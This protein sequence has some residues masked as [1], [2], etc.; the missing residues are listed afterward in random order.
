MAHLPIWYLGEVP[1]ADC[2]KAFSELISLPPGDATMG[3]TG[4]EKDQKTRDTIIR[5]ADHSHWFGKMMLDYGNLAN[6]ECNWGWITEGYEAIQ[7][8]EYRENQHYHWHVDNFPLSGNI[9]D[10]KITV[11]CLMNDPT[12][13]EGGGLELRLYQEYSTVLKKGS[14]VAF[15]SIIEHRVLPVTKGIRYS[16]T[17]WVNGPRFR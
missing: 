13:F 6:R 12:E 16:A 3:I 8:A 10:R 5:F 15:P 2:D 14:I 11:V 17:M 1:I 7:F 4:E 9:I